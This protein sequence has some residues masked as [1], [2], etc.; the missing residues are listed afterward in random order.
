[1]SLG[2]GVAIVDDARKGVGSSGV[3]SEV[4]WF[5]GGAARARGRRAAAFRGR[6]RHGRPLS[7]AKG[8]ACMVNAAPRVSALSAAVL[9]VRTCTY[10]GHAESVL[11]K[12][13]GA[14]ASAA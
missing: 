8:H 6:W 2:F 9:Y 5:R 1:L 7:A 4:G 14:R 11:H 12:H 10:A 3:S 13:T